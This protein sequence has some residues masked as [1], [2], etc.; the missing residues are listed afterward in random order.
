VQERSIGAKE[1][2]EREKEREKKF[3][4]LQSHLSLRDV[5]G[6]VLSIA[7]VHMEEHGGGIRKG[8]KGEGK[9]EQRNSFLFAD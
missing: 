4:R 9:D 1:G 8:G 2:R 6:M 7:R 3:Y 5:T